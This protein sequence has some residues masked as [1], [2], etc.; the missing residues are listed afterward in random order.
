VLPWTLTYC[1]WY[2]LLIVAQNY[3]WCAEKTKIG[4]VPLGI[5]L[6]ANI[7]LNLLLLPIWGL[8][9]AVLATTISTGLAL[10]LLY[11]LNRHEGMELKSGLLWLSAAP[12][13][14]GG[15]AWL[16]AAVLIVIL[17]AA[18][19]SKTLFTADERTVIGGFFRHQLELLSGFLTRRPKRV[20][21]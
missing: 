16:G 14:L 3:I 18:P 5:G 4:S 8:M 20:G 7:L 11:R 12:A 19:F 13:A 21:V 2:A 9:G 1:V 17:V 15:G 10:G 6:V